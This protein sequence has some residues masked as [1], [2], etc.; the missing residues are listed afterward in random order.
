MLSFSE[1]IPIKIKKILKGSLDSIPSPSP[2]VKIKI[3]DNSQQCF[4]LL[5]QVDFIDNNLNFHQIQ[6]IFLN[7]FYFNINFALFIG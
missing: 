2:S 5:L 3:I 1:R 7:L 4:T 6:D